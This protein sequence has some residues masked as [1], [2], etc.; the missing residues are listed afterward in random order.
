MLIWNTFMARDPAYSGGFPGCQHQGSSS[1]KTLLPALHSAMLCGSAQFVLTT[2]QCHRIVWK[3][4]LPLSP[5]PL[6][7]GTE[8]KECCAEGLAPP[9]PIP[10]FNSVTVHPKLP[11]IFPGDSLTHTLFNTHR[12]V[13]VFK[14]PLRDTEGHGYKFKVTRVLGGKVI[15]HVDRHRAINL[16]SRISVSPLF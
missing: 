3:N 14:R 7:L 6:V 2:I 11:L 4:F 16:L 8:A 9:H 5:I 12:N 1:K 13:C 10:N 15:Y